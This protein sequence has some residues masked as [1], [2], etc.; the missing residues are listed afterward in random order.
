VV[1]LVV[2]GLV[3]VGDVVVLVLVEGSVCVVFVGDVRVGWLV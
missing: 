1:G 3:V 2:V